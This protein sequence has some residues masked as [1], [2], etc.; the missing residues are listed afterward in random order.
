MLT[1][2][3]TWKEGSSR[4]DIDL[5]KMK[6]ELWSEK[7]AGDETMCQTIS[8][9]FV[10]VSCG[11]AMKKNGDQPLLYVVLHLQHLFGYR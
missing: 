1:S 5:V 4:G 7:L 3:N 11:S 8:D 9:K 10:L 2:I 6:A